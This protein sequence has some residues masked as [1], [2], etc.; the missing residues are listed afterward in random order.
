LFFIKKP[1]TARKMKCA[2]WNVNGIRAA[3]K[4]TFLSWLAEE[5]PD[6]VCLQETK[7]KK[8]QLP[9]ELLNPLGYFS[10]WH[11]AEK[12][13][14]S[15]VAF[16]SKKKISELQMGLGEAQFDQE[17]RVIIA[18]FEFFT[19][20]NAYFPNS[21][22]EHTRLDYKLA[23][24][25]SMLQYCNQLQEQGKQIVLC[26]DF[27]IAHRPIDLKNPQQNKDS[28]G[29]LPEERAW[30]D[31]LL[32]DPRGYIDTFRHF[33]QD[34]DH[35]TWWSYRP[36]VRAKNIGWRIDYFVTS[37]G[38]QPYLKTTRHQPEVLGSDH[39]PVILEI[40]LPK[41]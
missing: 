40:K 4:K 26:G 17:G 19:L 29:F 22:P 24:C 34:P 5:Q 14:Y 41:K 36:G 6:I 13:G 2:S 9:E 15:G 25:N 20:I 37:T 35:Y 11:S 32:T 30:M 31:Q 8:E 12:P 1:D 21:Q 16:Y 10:Y 7:A 18:E 39:C 27:N 38:M 33:V 28:S 3:G 23:F